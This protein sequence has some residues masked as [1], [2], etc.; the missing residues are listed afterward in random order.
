MVRRALVIF[1]PTAAAGRAAPHLER[2]R[3]ILPTLGLV[4][5]YRE[6]R[7]A[8]H[9]V[10]LAREAADTG[11][12]DVIVAAGGDGTAREVAVTT[13]LPADVQLDGDLI[14]TT[15]ARFQNRPLRPNVI[16]VPLLRSSAIWSGIP[17]YCT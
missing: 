11:T 12:C 2:L 7:A 16:A 8:G 10:A 15:P 4:A 13:A 1:N 9:A 5:M 6:S 17:R 14:G 3:P